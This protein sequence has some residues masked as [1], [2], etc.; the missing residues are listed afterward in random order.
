VTGGG[1]P[2]GMRGFKGG[3]G[4]FGGLLACAA[5]H[6]GAVTRVLACWTG[7]RRGR[8][9]GGPGWFLFLSSRSHG[10]GLGRGDGESTAG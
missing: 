2:G 1:G 3:C 10:R 4:G 8:E 7:Q 5:V 6:C 9:M